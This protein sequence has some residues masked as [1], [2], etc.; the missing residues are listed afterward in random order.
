MQVL[1]HGFAFDHNHCDAHCDVSQRSTFEIVLYHRRQG[2]YKLS[3]LTKN[4]WRC[5]M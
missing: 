3:C 4:M 1:A 2:G 5:L